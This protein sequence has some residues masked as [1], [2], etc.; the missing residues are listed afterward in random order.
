MSASESL[1]TSTDEKLLAIANDEARI[2]ITSDK[3]FG[4]LVYRHKSAHHGILLLR[5]AELNPQSIAEIVCDFI[6][7]HL[8]ELPMTFCVFSPG[9]VRIRPMQ[10]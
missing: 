8:A 7:A 1:A 9:Y 4:E 5:L 2:L 6:T 10:Q 3:D